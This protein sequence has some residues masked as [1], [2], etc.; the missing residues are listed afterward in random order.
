MS[1]RKLRDWNEIP[2]RLGAAEGGRE[3]REAGR[4]P[5]CGPH[6][7]SDPRR[8]KEGPTDL[9]KAPRDLPSGLALMKTRTLRP[10]GTR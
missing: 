9:L 5:L 6:T 8:S 2:T 1:S 7:L 4:T 3:R 10:A